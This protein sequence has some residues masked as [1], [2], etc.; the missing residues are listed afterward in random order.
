MFLGLAYNHKISAVFY[1]IVVAP[2]L[3]LIGLNFFP[4]LFVLYRKYLV[5]LGIIVAIY[6]LIKLYKLLGLDKKVK[7]ITKEGMN[8][9]NITE[10]YAVHHVKVFD[11][12]PGFSHP[13]L[14]I[15]PGEC[16]I[17]T[18]IGDDQHNITS[19]DNVYSMHPDGKF[20]SEYLLPGDTYGIKFITSGVFP[21]YCWN[22]KGYMRG[23]VVVK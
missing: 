18:N 12:N 2:L 3:I 14:Y 9:A 5:V 11:S 15:K 6:S 4:N 23:I 10:C 13:V 22:R 1:L 21:Y 20:R 19:T 8:G 7:E 16:V 17:W